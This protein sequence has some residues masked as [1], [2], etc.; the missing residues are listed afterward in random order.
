M[1]NVNVVLIPFIN[2]ETSYINKYSEMNCSTVSDSITSSFNII[3]N[4]RKMCEVC[5]KE[6]RTIKSVTGKLTMS[7]YGFK[8]PIIQGKNIIKYT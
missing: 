6:K 7:T 5:K 2:Q 3:E 1:L 8:V 4:K